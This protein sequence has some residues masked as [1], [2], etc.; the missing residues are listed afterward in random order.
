M[1]GYTF[2]LRERTHNQTCTKNTQAYTTLESF[3]G[4]FVSYERDRHI[5]SYLTECEIKSVFLFDSYYK[6]QPL[7]KYYQ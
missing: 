2:S 7:K 1:P 6:E 3:N 4:V 5:I